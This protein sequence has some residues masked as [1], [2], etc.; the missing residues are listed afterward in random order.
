MPTIK[1]KKMQKDIKSVRLDRMFFN[2]SVWPV[3][4]MLFATLLLITGIVDDWFLIEQFMNF[5]TSE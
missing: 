3:Y 2:K 1:V 5:L 4:V